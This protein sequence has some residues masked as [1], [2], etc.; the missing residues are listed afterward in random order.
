LKTGRASIAWNAALEL[1]H[2]DLQD[3]LVLVLLVVDE[4][5]FARAS[6]RW[7]GWLCLEVPSLTLRQLL[8]VAQRFGGA[9]RS[10]AALALEASCAELGL[11]RAAAATHAAYLQR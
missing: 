7:L 6:T 9:A 8:L 1:E 5:R 4:P 10:R 2:I 3:A 11:T